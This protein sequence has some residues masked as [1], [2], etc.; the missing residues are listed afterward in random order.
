MG[1]RGG[2]LV[3]GVGNAD[4]GDDGAGIEVVRI[5]AASGAPCIV[6][7]GDGLGLIDAWDGFAYVVIVDAV[8]GGPE[9]GSFARFDTAVE[10]LPR[11]LGGNVHGVGLAQT[12]EI[13]RALG[14]LPRVLVVYALGAASFALG[15]G[16]AAPVARAC[17]EVAERIDEEIRLFGDPV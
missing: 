6:H 2:S 8:S 13:A 3:I 17:A 7:E 16:P 14:R 11:H 1:G 12:I 9:P 10:P 15:E 5:L 4:R